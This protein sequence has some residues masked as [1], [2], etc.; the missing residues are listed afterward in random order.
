LRTLDAYRRVISDLLGAM[1][2]VATH[3]AAQPGHLG[4]MV[5][6]VG[7]DPAAAEVAQRHG[8]AA[9]Q[10][11]RCRHD[12]DDPGPG[13]NLSVNGRER[14]VGHGDAKP[15][16]AAIQH[17][18]DGFGRHHIGQC[19][20]ARMR[21]AEAPQSARNERQRRRCPKPQGEQRRLCRAASQAQAA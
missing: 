9:R 3:A 11:M 18:R 17:H 16:L 21:L 19:S 13:E 4:G 10:P 7:P 2:S 14:L 8:A 5:F 1:P 6:M 20:N 12:A 15:C